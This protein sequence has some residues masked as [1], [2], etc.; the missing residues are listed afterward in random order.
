MGELNRTI[1]SKPAALRKA[2]I[3][4]GLLAMALIFLVGAAFVYIAYNLTPVSTDKQA[5]KVW[6]DIPK[7]ASTAQIGQKLAQAHL[8]RNQQ[9]FTLY[10]R[11]YQLGGKLQSG[12]Y[13]LSP[14]ENLSAIVSDI[15]RGPLTVRV[16]IP[17]G[18]ST[19]QI[20]DLL[21]REKLV[22]KDKFFAAVRSGSFGYDFLNGLPA[23]NSRL[24]GYLFPATYKIT[25]GISETEIIK[26][27][28]ARFAQ[29]YTPQ[30]RQAIAAKSWTVEKWVTL[31]SIVE[32]EAQQREDRP[33]VAGIFVKRLRQGMPLQSDATIQYIFGFSKAKLYVK[34]LQVKSPYNSYLNK[35]L[36]PGPIANPGRSSL[37]AAAFPAQSDYL[38]F[39]T[40]PD[41]SEAYAKTFPE[42]Q[43]NV[44]KYLGPAH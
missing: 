29:E 3:V 25:P 9:V 7:G 38:Y 19:E 24:E 41:G 43:Q 13:S 33:I 36:P 6:I 44:A 39:V 21:V 4:T 10:V 11:Y 16:T 8:I 35:G 42:H 5:A 2:L 30:V 34:D 17:E 22:D 31:A 15:Y 1:A 12:S 23:T 20:A 14:A 37:L 27:M 28:L 18:Y 40:K 26:L 32:K